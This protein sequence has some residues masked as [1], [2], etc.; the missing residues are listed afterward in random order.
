MNTG[1]HC[2]QVFTM[3]TDLQ[4]LI[5]LLMPLIEALLMFAADFLRQLLA[6]VLL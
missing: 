4:S 6:A 2:K 1:R 5:D 3:P